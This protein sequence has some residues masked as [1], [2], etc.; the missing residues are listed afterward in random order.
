M[1]LNRPDNW[2]Q[3]PVILNRHLGTKNTTSP[4]GPSGLPHSWKQIFGDLPTLIPQIK[5]VDITS[6]VSSPTSSDLIMQNLNHKDV[7]QN[8]L[9]R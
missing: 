7:F 8:F 9:F 1:P 5:A 6:G 3:M 2:A 4:A